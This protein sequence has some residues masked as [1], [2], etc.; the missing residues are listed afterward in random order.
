MPGI[1]AHYRFGKQMLQTLSPKQKQCVT[2]FRRLYDMGLYGPDIFDYWH[3]LSASSGEPSADAFH[4]RSGREF[5]TQAVAQAGSEGARAYLYGLLAHYCLDSQCAAFSRRK[6]EEGY[7]LPA[8]EGEFDRYLL[9][10][11]GLSDN[12]DLSRHMQLTRGESVTVSQFY[13]PATAAQTHSSIRNMTHFCHLLS[14][15]K[16]GFVAKLLILAGKPHY[17]QRLRLPSPDAEH[18]RIDSEL[19]ARCNRAAKLYPV[20]LKQLTAAMEAGEPLG[21]EFDPSFR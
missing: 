17:Q 1:Y 12:Y 21:P 13:P 7:S 9:E 19:L 3:P 2:R 10:A 15:K 18:L 5:F 14:R 11:D 4:L 6:R 20:L 8:M 16:R